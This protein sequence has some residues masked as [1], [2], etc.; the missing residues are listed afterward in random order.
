M[1]GRG[2][3][4]NPALARM[5]KLGAGAALPWEGLL[6]LLED[7]WRLVVLRTQARTAMRADE[8]MA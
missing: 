3:L 4:A 2:M 8:A 7:F 5:I 1:L 6:P